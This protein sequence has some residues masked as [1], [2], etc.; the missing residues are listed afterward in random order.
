MKSDFRRELRIGIRDMTEGSG[1][2][3]RLG[4][5]SFIARPPIAAPADPQTNPRRAGGR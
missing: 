5:D 1:K 4:D 3:T 2:F